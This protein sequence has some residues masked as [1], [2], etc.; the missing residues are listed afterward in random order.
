MTVVEKE[1]D[2]E[3][4]LSTNVNFF[5]FQVSS[6]AFE[7]MPVH[8]LCG[9][10]SNNTTKLLLLKY[11]KCFLTVL[12]K[13]LGHINLNT[14]RE[15]RGVIKAQDQVKTISGVCCKNDLND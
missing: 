11:S 14:N 8:I 7:S 6:S 1:T 12:L 4:V 9:R 13:V 5:C 3:H 10:F 2:M 15:H